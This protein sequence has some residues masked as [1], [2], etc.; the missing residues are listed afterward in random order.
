MHRDVEAECAPCCRICLSTDNH[1]GLF[2]AGHELISPCRCKGSQQFVHRSCLDQWRGVKVI[3]AIAGVTF[4]SDRDG[5]FRNRFTDWM[6]SKH[7]LPFYYCVGV[8]FFFALVGLF[9]LL[10]HCFSCDYGGDDPSYLPEPECSYGCLDC[11]TSRTSRSGDDDDCIC[12]VIMVVV[13]V[14]ALLG[15]FYGFIAATMA[16]QK[17]MQRHYHILKKKEL[18]KVYVVKDL[19][20]VTRCHP[21]WTQSTSSA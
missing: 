13:L 17:I 21:R 12:V 4:L 3:V 16:F 11:E 8:V 15:I 10:S 2:G 5:K 19:K 20:G 14:F 18:T 6:L 9:G 7:P 1:R